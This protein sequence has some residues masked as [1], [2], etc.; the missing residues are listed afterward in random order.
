MTFYIKQND[1]TPAIKATL[2]DGDGTVI[3]LTDASVRFHMRKV[4]G[5][6]SVVDS[7]A[8]VVSPA[9]S[10]IVQYSWIG[11]DTVNTGLYS[12]EFEI[13][14]GNGKI[15][16]FPNSDYIRVEIVDDIA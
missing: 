14:Y 10:G 12:A 16:T 6:T 3:N 1:T 11:A 13:T 5:E 2:K 15:E 8:T 9:T 7:A 4:G